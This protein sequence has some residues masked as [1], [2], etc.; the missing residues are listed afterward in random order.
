M[1]SRTLSND[2]SESEVTRVM[3]GS[4]GG[5]LEALDDLGR[6][7]LRGGISSSRRAFEAASHA[8]GGSGRGDVGFDGARRWKRRCDSIFFFCLVI[9]VPRHLSNTQTQTVGGEGPLEGGQASKSP[10]FGAMPS[11]GR[12]RQQIVEIRR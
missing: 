3:G 1:S 11:T 2:R 6:A 12:E 5:A 9:S 7:S 4:I 8:G 10:V